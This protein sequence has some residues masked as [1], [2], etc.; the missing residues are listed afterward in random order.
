V[1]CWYP[2]G[3][4]DEIF[5]WPVLHNHIC[6]VIHHTILNCVFPIFT[7]FLQIEGEM[8]QGLRLTSAPLQSIIIQK[9]ETARLQGVSILTWQ[10]YCRVYKLQLQHECTFCKLTLKHSQN[11]L[12]IWLIKESKISNCTNLEY[13]SY[14]ITH[15]VYCFWTS[16]GI[17]NSGGSTW[18]TW[19]LCLNV[20]MTRKRWILLFL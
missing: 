9:N 12:H 11:D 16:M 6:S 7:V 4:Q 13:I 5:V 15:W 1:N 8:L 3:D 18:T 14:H 20:V 19:Y 17:F 2:N 10:W